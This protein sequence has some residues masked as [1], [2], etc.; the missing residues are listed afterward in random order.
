MSAPLVT[1]LRDDALAARKR[2]VLRDEDGRVAG[3]RARLLTTVIAEAEGLAKRELREPTDEDA[4][5]ALRRTLKGVDESLDLV[6]APD[7][8][9]A[10]EEEKTTLSDYVPAYLEGDDLR[11]EIAQAAEH[12][13]VPVEMRSMRPLMDAMSALHPGKIDGKRVAALIK[14]WGS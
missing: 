12:L 7:R 4:A 13:G 9:A 5:T 10:L 14:S 6:T 1:R 8:R 2:A 3:V 11:A